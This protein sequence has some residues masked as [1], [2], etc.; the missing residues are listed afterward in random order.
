MVSA[1]AISVGLQVGFDTAVFT[2]AIVFAM[3]VN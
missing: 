2:V 1:S 3:I